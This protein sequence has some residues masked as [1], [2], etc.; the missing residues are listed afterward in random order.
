[1]DKRTA[2]D[3][4]QALHQKRMAD[5]VK[6][7]LDIGIQNP[8]ALA[9]CTYTRPGILKGI[10]RASSRTE[11]ITVGL[12]PRFPAWFK[13]IFDHRLSH[14]VD[15]TGNA[16]RASWPSTP[17]VRLPGLSCVTRRTA[18]Y[19]FARLR[20]ISFIRLRTRLGCC[21]WLAR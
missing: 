20:S 19:R 21:N 16:Q 3:V 12:K 10:M 13:R 5:L 2:W 15:Q 6:R 4:S 9:T 18:A 17:G 8:G 11:A 7:A 1:M 14:S